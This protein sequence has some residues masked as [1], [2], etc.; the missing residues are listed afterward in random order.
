MRRLVQVLTITSAALC[1]TSHAVAD[2]LVDIRRACIERAN[3]HSGIHWVEECLQEAFTAQPIH[4]AFTPIAPGAGIVGLGPGF[5]IT[6]RIRSFEFILMGKAVISNDGSTLGQAQMIFALPTPNIFLKDSSLSPIQEDNPF[7]LGRKQKSNHLDAKMSVT[8]GLRRFDARE[9]DF[10]GLGPNSTLL[11]HASYGLIMTETYAEINAPITSWNAAGFQFSF[12]TPRITSSISSATPQMRSVYDQ[13]SAPG[14]SSR[15]DF[16]HYEPYLVFNLPPRR[17]YSTAMRLGYAF[18]QD[19][20]SARFSFQRLSANSKTTIPLWLPSR[21]TPNNRSWY[22]N[23][24]CPSLRSGTR[25][26]LG[27]IAVSARVETSHYGANSQVPFYLDPTLGGTDISGS[28]TLRGFV[29]YRFRGP[30]DVLFQIDYRRPI[31]GPV[32]LLAFYD[33]GKV[34]LRPADISFDHLRKDFGLGF[35]LRAGNNEIV[36]FYLGFGTGEPASFK[37]KFPNS[38]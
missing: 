27:N 16:L 11:G 31:W 14:L 28:D 17:S 8:L 2:D 20:V 35:Y 18:Y 38:F 25:C 15:D 36:R 33:R 3:L 13:F 12:L 4:I 34:A 32:G 21:G 5:G 7:E 9:Q 26:S 19:T 29:D 30:S 6:P 24:V 37:A 23:Y 10:Y 1:W 22:A